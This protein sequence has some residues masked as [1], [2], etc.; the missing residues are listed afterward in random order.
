MSR[1]AVREIGDGN[2]HRHYQKAGF[3]SWLWI[4]QGRGRTGILFP[5]QWHRRRL[6]R[7]PGWREGPVR[8]RVEPQ[9]PA[10]QERPHSLSSKTRKAP[11][12]SSGLFYLEFP[13]PLPWEGQ[14]ERRGKETRSRRYACR[15]FISRGTSSLGWGYLGSI[16]RS[17][18]T[19]I[20]VTAQF[21]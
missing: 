20:I 13:S 18:A 9:G 2:A 1:P 6:R 8:N 4:H 21:R 14:G 3:G 15:R 7:P 10:R 5:P 17:V 12:A 11:S 16:S 19:R